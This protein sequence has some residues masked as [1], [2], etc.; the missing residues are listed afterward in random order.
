V[1]VGSYQLIRPF[2]LRRGAT[3]ILRHA[4]ARERSRREYEDSVVARTPGGVVLD[5]RPV[6]LR[7]RIFVGHFRAPMTCA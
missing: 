3:P 4:E 6:Y 1:H 7:P 2:G 5:C